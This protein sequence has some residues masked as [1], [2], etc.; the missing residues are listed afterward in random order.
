M[1]EEGIVDQFLDVV[2]HFGTGPNTRQMIARPHS[3][4][5]SPSGKL[6]AVCDKGNDTVRMYGLDRQSRKRVLP[7]HIYHHSP[8]SMPRYCVFHPEHHWFYQNNENGKELLAFRYDEEGMLQLIDVCSITPNDIMM[9]EDILE[10]QELVMNRQGR[11]L[12]DVIRGP[13]VIAVLEINQQTGSAKSIQQQKLDGM[14]PRSCTI[15]SDGQFLLD[16]CL[17][18]RYCVFANSTNGGE[19][20]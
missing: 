14:W 15:S 2:K 12:Y 1:N 17:F 18:F 19:Q 5:M 10:Q 9:Q 20:Q 16:V 8:G 4:V 6:F 11:Y 3:V 13:N 7:K